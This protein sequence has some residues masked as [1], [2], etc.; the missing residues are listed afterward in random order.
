MTHSNVM[1]MF[2]EY[3]GRKCFCEE[4][5]CI[6]AWSYISYFNLFILLKLLSIWE[7]FQ[8][9]MLRSIAFDIYFLCF[10]NTCRII[11]IHNS[12]VNLLILTIHILYLLHGVQWSWHDSKSRQKCMLLR[13][14]R[15][16]VT[17]LVKTYLVC[18]ID[19]CGSDKY[20]ASARPIISP[21]EFS[22]Y[23]KPKSTVPFQ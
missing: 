22:G 11:F 17:T 6:V 8:M 9:N 23:S 19:L 15:Y 2:S 13:M 16:S 18:N 3:R 10:S 20:L 1:N 21:L 12:C 14:H 5:S 7:E 4:V